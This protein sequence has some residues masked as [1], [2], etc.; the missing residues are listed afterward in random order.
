[1]KNLVY[2]LLLLAAGYW[3][4]TRCQGDSN[5][6]E[7]VLKR[8]KVSV[9][10]ANLRTGPGTSYDFA[11]TGG[12]ATGDKLQVTRGTVL[13]VVAVKNGWYQVRIPG[14]S[15]TAYIKQTLCTDMHGAKGKKG[16]KGRKTQSNRKASDNM[17]TQK[18]A[19][20]KSATPAPSTSDDEVVEEVKGSSA[21]D[22]VL[23]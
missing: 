4:Y 19:S 3:V 22:E 8:V 10:T 16:G 14:D 5:E 13:Q 9:K 6:D 18:S 15:T 17:P 7:G 1:M 11:T 2:L 21:D 20:T 12:D 23:F